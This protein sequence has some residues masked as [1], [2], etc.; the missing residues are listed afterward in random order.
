MLLLFNLFRADESG[1]W[2]K[3]LFKIL[4]VDEARKKIP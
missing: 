1:Y 4:G 3:Y 2:R